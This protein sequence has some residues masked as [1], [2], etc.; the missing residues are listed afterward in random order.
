MKIA[1]NSTE[2]K[3]YIFQDF[4]LFFIPHPIKKDLS[5]L[6]DEKSITQSI[7]NLILTK[8]YEKPFRPEIGSNVSRML[9]EHNL[10]HNELMLEREIS[11]IITNFE[12]RV[13]LQNVQVSSE[14]DHIMATI[15]YYMINGTELKRIEIPFSR[16]NI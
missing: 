8:H 3:E 2:T 7:K 6:K 4:D 16:N 12:P 11:D 15:S 14:S 10:I 5:L 13:K 1:L 9:F